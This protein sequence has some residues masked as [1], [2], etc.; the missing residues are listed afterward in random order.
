MNQLA[1]QSA[2]SLKIQ[3]PKSQ[4]GLSYSLKLLSIMK[5]KYNL[6]EKRLWKIKANASSEVK[7]CV[8]NFDPP[9]GL[10]QVF[11]LGVGQ[12]LLLSFDQNKL[13]IHYVKPAKSNEPSQ[14]EK[15]LILPHLSNEIIFE[16]TET[17]Q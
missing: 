13:T 9:L 4:T 12:W 14:Y 7:N 1:N 10:G 3:K 6:L 8:L 16:F 5:F 17:D 11:K 2:L 15:K